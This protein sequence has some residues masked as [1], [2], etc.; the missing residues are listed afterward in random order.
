MQAWCMTHP[1]MT[2]FLLWAPLVS[3][4]LVLQIVLARAKRR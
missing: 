1:W 4:N 3:V 2:F